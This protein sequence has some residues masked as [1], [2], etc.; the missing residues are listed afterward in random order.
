M[1][2]SLGSCRSTRA[3]AEVGLVLYVTFSILT[4]VPQVLMSL[5]QE[6]EFS[7]TGSYSSERRACFIVYN[8]CLFTWVWPLSEQSFSLTNCSLIKEGTITL[9]LFTNS[10]IFKHLNFPTIPCESDN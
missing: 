10:F 5:E 8:Q 2:I 1:L 7:S 4:R 6:V 3:H 9:N